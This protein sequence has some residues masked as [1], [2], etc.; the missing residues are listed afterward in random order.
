M[1]IGNA[2]WELYCLE[3]GIGRDGVQKCDENLKSI[4]DPS[5]GTFFDETPNGKVVPRAVMIDL[6]PSVIDE[7]RN[8]PYKNLYHPNQLIN[9]KED[10]ANNYARGHYTV[11]QEVSSIR[12]ICKTY[13]AFEICMFF[14]PYKLI[15][16]LRYSLEITVYLLL[17]FWNFISNLQAFFCLAFQRVIYA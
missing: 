16:F 1:Q 10:A 13:F 11:G 9:H 15:F 7:I 6:E 3:H 8:G 12:L 14:V 4:A 17:T 2:C 5:L